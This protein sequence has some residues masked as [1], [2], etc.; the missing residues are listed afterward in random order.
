LGRGR[1][2][3]LKSGIVSWRH[4]SVNGA[5]VP[6][7]DDPLVLVKCAMSAPSPPIDLAQLARYTG[8]E[9]QLDAEVLALFRRECASAVERLETLLGTADGKAWREAAHRLKGAA[10][11][12]GAKA[13]ADLAGR[14]EA[15]EPRAMPAEAADALRALKAQC[16]IVAAFI[17]TYLAE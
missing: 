7:G 12:V 9:P 3:K 10:A 13:L 8:G 1:A 16:G 5:F 17:E 2:D 11:A 4:G 6:E 14:A 15:I